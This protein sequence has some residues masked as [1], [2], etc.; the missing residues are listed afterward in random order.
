ML[1]S[2]G[3]SSGDEP[4]GRSTSPPKKRSNSPFRLLPAPSRISPRRAGP[5]PSGR[6]NELAGMLDSARDTEY[7]DDEDQLVVDRPRDK[8]P[9][10]VVP[11]RQV[12]PTV[13]ST[14]DVVE[15]ELIVVHVTPSVVAAVHALFGVTSQWVRRTIAS[16]LRKLLVRPIIAGRRAAVVVSDKLV[17]KNHAAGAVNVVSALSRAIARSCDIVCPISVRPAPLRV[18]MGI[19]ALTYIVDRRERDDLF[20]SFVALYRHSRS[21]HNKL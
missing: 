20:H 21:I 13:R 4:F 18:L 1:V 9:T 14:T 16:A 8:S 10:P 11:A 12:S 15:P 5:T 3:S 19:Q 17:R 2:D 6:L 7:D